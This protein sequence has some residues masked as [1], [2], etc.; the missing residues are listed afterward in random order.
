MSNVAVKE[1][2]VQQNMIYNTVGSLVYY[3]CQWITTILI[4]KLSGYDDA[5]ILSL[6]MSASAAP[7]II[8]L[9]NVRSYQVSDIRDE[10]K[11]D[12]Y[13]M[14]RFYTNVLAFVT[15][16]VLAITQGYT[17]WKILCIMAFMFV[18]ISESYADVYYGIEQKLARMDYTGIS[19]AARGIGSLALFVGILWLF[20]N[21]FFSILSMAVFSFGFAFLF[22]RRIVK[23]WNLDKTTDVKLF[24]SV[25][26]LLLICYPLAIVAFFNNLSINMP[27]L[28][29]EKYFGE[30]V[31]GIYSSVASPTMVIQLAATTLFAP[32]VPVLTSYFTEKK[33]SEFINTL[34]KFIIL[35]LGIFVVSVIG[36]IFLARWALTL[37]FNEQIADYVYLFIPVI[38]VALLIAIN[39]SLFSVCTLLRAI[40]SQYIIA[41]LGM[42]ASFIMSVT[43]LKSTQMMGVIYASITTLVVQII[44]QCI[45]IF[46]KIKDM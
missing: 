40:K 5:G 2:S 9:F 33:K 36:S 32:M 18:R 4:V 23:S 34:K 21:L 37:I 3:L 6:A 39:A 19:L 45:I 20:N 35:V 12:A 41:A 8:A 38:G 17:V 24:D 1:K 16:F 31:M 43:V 42:L 44:V 22:D 46:R 27:K 15:C 28:F 13:I 25:K 7:S 30:E 11:P 29:L 10:F 14:A 26:K